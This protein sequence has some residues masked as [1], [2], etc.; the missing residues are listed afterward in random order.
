MRRL[1]SE[2]EEL[3]DLDVGGI[4]GL[5]HQAGVPLEDDSPDHDSEQL[6]QG[7]EDT[8]HDVAGFLWALRTVT[9]L[10]ESHV[11]GGRRARHADNGG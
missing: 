10:L 6:L 2:L 8:E 7:V 1:E 3:S 9:D 5:W 4:M 11:E